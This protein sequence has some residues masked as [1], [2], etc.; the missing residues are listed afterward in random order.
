MTDYQFMALAKL[1]LVFT[2]G[3]IVISS[4]R[5]VQEFWAWRAERRERASE[6]KLK[7]IAEEALA[8]AE[9]LTIKSFEGVLTGEIATIEVAPVGKRGRTARSKALAAAAEFGHE[10]S[11]DNLIFPVAEDEV[12]GDGAV[13]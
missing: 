6:A 3:M 13:I 4:T 7:S 5:A 12:I 2:G 9:E 10:L 11:D 1:L 8:V